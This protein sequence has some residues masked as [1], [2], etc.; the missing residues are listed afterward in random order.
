MCFCSDPLQRRGRQV[1]GA[2]MNKRQASRLL[3][4]MLCIASLAHAPHAQVE[5]G[6]LVESQNFDTGA[7]DMPISVAAANIKKEATE[8]AASVMDV[9]KRDALQ[10]AE[11]QAHIRDLQDRVS[12]AKR[13][14]A[15][16]KLA[17]DK[18]VQAQKAKHSGLKE[19]G[20][21]E[22][23]QNDSTLAK[24]QQL[25]RMQARND[26][27]KELKEE[28]EKYRAE[29]HQLKSKLARAST[30]IEKVKAATAEVRHLSQMAEASDS[31][32][33][34]PSTKDAPIRPASTAS[35]GDQPRVETPKTAS[36]LQVSRREL[37]QMV[38][39]LQADKELEATAKAN[40][41][42]AHRAVLTDLHRL[43]QME[44][45]FA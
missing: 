6:N 27:L 2:G 11:K 20:E 7:F 18:A 16:I 17:A 22:T 19:L 36:K 37:Q 21:G 4:W 45:S 42:N 32:S 28:E 41:E 10:V 9:E 15:K 39:K 29:L 38:L 31:V 24:I 26:R 3:Q 34:A 33:S 5:T 30:A 40:E 1:R 13:L 44:Q 23:V 14:I 43:E 12:A 35:T 25:S 8:V